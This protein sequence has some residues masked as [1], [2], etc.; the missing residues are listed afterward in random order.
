MEVI[1]IS[2]RRL[3]RRAAPRRWFRSALDPPARWVL[4]GLAP[5]VLALAAGLSPGNAADLAYGAYLAAE[6]V[7]CH[8]AAPDDG[9]IPAIAG[10]PQEGFLQALREYRGGLRRHPVMQNVARSLDDRQIEALAAYF[11]AMQGGGPE[12]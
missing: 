2:G 1:R 8:G 9:A 10:L 4:V 6:C 5:P 3:A 7:T 12:R 11:A